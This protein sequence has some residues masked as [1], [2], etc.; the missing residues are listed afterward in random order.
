[1][2]TPMALLVNSF[3]SVTHRAFYTGRSGVFM[4]SGFIG[5]VP[6]IKHSGGQWQSHAGASKKQHLRI[7]WDS[8]HKVYHRQESNPRGSVPFSALSSA[9]QAV[10]PCSARDR[11]RSQCPHVLLQLWKC[12][13]SFAIC[14]IQSCTHSAPGS[15][16]KSVFGL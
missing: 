4:R 7:T 6:F 9:P 3:T 16:I 8:S 10:C 1:M 14:I 2:S 11:R 5:I 13:P 12:P 15:L